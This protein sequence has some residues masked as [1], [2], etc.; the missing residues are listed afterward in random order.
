MNRCRIFPG[1]AV[2]LVATVVLLGSLVENGMAQEIRSSAP[3]PPTAT[4]RAL[5]VCGLPGDDEHRATYAG[6]T[7]KIVTALVDR[8]GFAAKDVWVRFGNDPKAG[9]GPAIKGS[10]GLSTRENIA[11]DALAIQKAS[12]PND[13]LWVIVLGHAHFDGRRSHL[14]LP[15]PDLS[16]VTFAKLFEGIKAKEQVFFITTSASGFFLKPLAA[17]GRIA[18]SATEADQEVNETVFP[19]ALAD[20]LASA[21]PVA[22]LD[23][24]GNVSI[25]DLYLA[26]VADVRQ[27]YVADELIATEHA[28]LDDNGDGHGSELQLTFL[29]PEYPEKVEESKDK[30]AKPKPKEKEKPKPTLGPKDD[31]FL[32]S[33]TLLNVSKVEKN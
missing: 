15:G 13:L 22:D 30:K 29:P 8:H 25:L 17:P 11:A 6:A 14:N 2:G 20:T 23:K 21:L 33:K 9:D 19:L 4:R 1:P 28:Q 10:R 7:E 16:D 24:D 3:T 27:R 31:G 26:T 5:I 32:A 12:A 18:I